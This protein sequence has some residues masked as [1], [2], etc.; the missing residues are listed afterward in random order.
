M[1]KLLQVIN[2][3]ERLDVVSMHQMRRRVDNL[4]KPLGSLGCLEEIAIRLAGITGSV[5]PSVSQKAVVV[6]CGDHGV[7]QEGVSAFPQELTGL[8]MA[9]FIRRKA[10]VNV[11]AKQAGAEVH[12]VD[13]GT[14]LTELPADVIQRKVR[15]GTANMANEPAMTKDDAVAAI[16]AGID[17]AFELAGKGVELIGLGEMGIGNTTPSSAMMAVFTNRPVENITGRGSGITDEAL[18]AKVKVIERAIQVN[19]PD[20]TDAIDVLSKV[21]G[22]EIAGL[23]GVI[24]GAASRRI[25]VVLDGVITAAA[26]LAACR[27]EPRCRDYIFASHVSVEPAH[28]AALEELGLEPMLYLNMRLGEGTGAALAF[29]IMESAVQLVSEMATFDE[30]GIPS[31]ASEVDEYSLNCKG[32]NRNGREER[33]AASD[34]IGS[35]IV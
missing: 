29:P 23:T 13:V 11:L 33:Q 30:L 27:I 16:H 9:N 35:R 6:M 32:G 24:L 4:T 7:T 17:T 15:P 20:P 5:D 19:R 12:V 14:L 28:R 2:R 10:A 31:P 1:E 8:M 34:R 21:G 18:A 26:A 3:I 25:P 22:L